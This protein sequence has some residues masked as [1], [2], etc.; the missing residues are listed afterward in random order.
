MVV[1]LIM[2][3]GA[4]PFLNIAPAHAQENR[5]LDDYSQPVGFTYGL[6]ATVTTTYLWRSLNAG[7]MS[8]QG[9]ANVGYGGAYLDVWCNLGAT[10]WAFSRFLP[11]LDISLGFARWGLNVFVL[12]IHNFDCGF[13]DFNNYADRGNRLEINAKYTVSSKLP[14]SI[15]WATRVSAA[16][17]YLDGAGNVVR[18]WS[19]YL[20]LSYTHNFP[21]DI[22]LYGAIGITPWK[23]CYT[24]Y[25]LGAGVTN[26]DI[27]LRKD[28]SV[29]EHCGLMLRG[30]F[31]I[32]PTLLAAD[33][34]TAQWS[35]RD[36]GRQT[37]NA[38]LAFGVYLK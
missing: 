13:F 33:K 23:S 8:L 18:A 16:D 12:Y 5:W 15:L 22:S 26:I 29:S 19:S 20:E 30:E 21:Y 7:G 2:L 27:R 38:S 17:G 28:W 34:T 14:L 4:L 10:D 36:S 25:Q 9:D 35:L 31:C 3:I 24:G 6:S 11:E 37:I 1:A 32:N